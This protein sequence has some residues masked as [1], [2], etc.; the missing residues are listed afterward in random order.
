MSVPISRPHALD[1]RSHLRAGLTLLPLCDATF[2]QFCE[3]RDRL[4]PQARLRFAP[5]SW[6]GLKLKVEFRAAQRRVRSG[7]DC[8][9]LALS[10]ESR[11][12][13]GLGALWGV[14]GDSR[15]PTIGVCV[16]DTH[17]RV[18]LGSRLVDAL[19]LSATSVGARGVELTTM[20]DNC[21]GLGLAIAKGF[22]EV[23]RTFVPLGVQPDWTPQSSLRRPVW[24]CERQL[25]LVLEEDARDQV[26]SELSRRRSYTTTLA[27][28]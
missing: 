15:V 7:N 9:F 12:P 17:K 3:F 27:G 25:A 14:R 5:F 28:R 10:G 26:N 19:L 11:A 8:V 22:H 2:G 21:A 1:L 23:G 16:I 4:G 13:V 6:E 18:G 24:R 20:L